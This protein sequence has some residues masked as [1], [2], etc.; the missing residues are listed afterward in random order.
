M[1]TNM[2]VCCNCCGSEGGDRYWRQ[3]II[4]KGYMNEL[5]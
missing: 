4:L 2:Y 1:V 5:S 3:L